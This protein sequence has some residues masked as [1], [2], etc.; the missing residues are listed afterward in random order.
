[1]GRGQHIV[2]F[3]W[4][5]HR[6]GYKLEESAASGANPRQQIVPKSYRAGV[7]EYAPLCEHTGLFRAFAATKP[8]P[9]GC[10]AF[11]DKYGGLLGGH[12]RPEN[13]LDW[14][15]H[16]AEMTRAV[17]LWDLISRGD[18]EGL[19]RHIVW[20]K[21]R[22]GDDEVAYVPAPDALRDE[23]STIATARMAGGGLERFQ[24]GDVFFPAVL[25]VR[26]L[27]NRR[28]DEHV[29]P[30]LNY[31]GESDRP[32]GLV[33]QM[34]P[35]NLL[36]ALWLQFAQGVSGNREYRQCG[37]CREWFE[38][39]PGR[40]RSDKLYCSDACRARAYRERPQRATRMRAEGRPVVEIAK[41]LNADE[42]QVRKWLKDQKKK[43]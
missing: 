29:A 12:G 1:M 6:D 41:I 5:V 13:L 31:D 26:G 25:Y 8:T 19:A 10:I 38:V 3:T 42:G 43:G 9:E 36:G 2:E 22:E 28:L 18:T 7:R 37:G 4:W 40:S 17:E 11:A 30:R 32:G 27:A 23:W 33:L 24:H 21:G 20:V 35:K 39:S 16:V 15:L 34:E 14:Q